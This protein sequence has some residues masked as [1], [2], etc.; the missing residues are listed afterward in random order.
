[1]ELELETDGASRGNPGPAAWAYLLRSGGEVLEERTG[2]IGTATNNVAEYQALIE[3]LERARELGATRVRVRADSEL[4]VRQLNGQYRVK[5]PGLKPLHHRAVELLKA[6]GGTVVHVRRERNRRTDRMVNAALDGEAAGASDPGDED[7][8]HL[9]H[10]RGGR[11]RMVDVGSK[12]L[13]GREAVAEAVVRLSPA[14]R[15]ALESGA[16][17]KGDPLAVA[18]L[19]AVQA[20]KRTAELIPLC[21]P[22]ALD[23]IEVEARQEGEVVRITARVAATGKTGVEMEAMT[24]V[25]VAALTVYDMLKSADKG[26]IVE[27]V[28]LLAKSGGKSGEWQAG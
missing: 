18:E 22:L 13:T 24:A 11:P 16:G 4:M 2:R 17:R 14:A 6:V 19:A 3:G 5:S 25:A 7:G 26:L 23:V 20:A 27:S 10:L 12:D 15:R 8:P 9:S 28:R 1:V 21:H